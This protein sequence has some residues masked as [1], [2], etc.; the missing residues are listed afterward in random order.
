M[1]G[2]A[3]EAPYRKSERDIQPST[4]E[5][6]GRLEDIMR[7]LMLVASLIAVGGIAGQAFAA[8]APAKARYH[9]MNGRTLVWHAPQA[10]RPYALRGAPAEAEKPRIEF[11]QHGRAGTSLAVQPEKSR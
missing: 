11:R 1:V 10:E 3:A 2:Y 4:P 9:T 8:E 5:S 6:K 7:K